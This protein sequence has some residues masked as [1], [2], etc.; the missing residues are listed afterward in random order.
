MGISS[1]LDLRCDASWVDPQCAKN[2]FSI[3][4]SMIFFFFYSCCIGPGWLFCFSTFRFLHVP[5]GCGLDAFSTVSSRSV[6]SHAHLPCNREGI[7]SAAFMRPGMPPLGSNPGSPR[8]V[9]KFAS[10]FL[11]A[12]LRLVYKVRK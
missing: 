4:A 6:L 3:W 12:R 5:V 10:S 9:F 7:R 2:L 11:N 8:F 1:I